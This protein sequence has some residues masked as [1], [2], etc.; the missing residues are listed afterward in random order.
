MNELPEGVQ[1][2]FAHVSLPNMAER[3]NGGGGGIT[4][5]K[6][7]VAFLHICVLVEGPSVLGKEGE[8]G[9]ARGGGG[10]VNVTWQQ[11][12][13]HGWLPRVMQHRVGGPVT[14]RTFFTR[15]TSWGCRKIANT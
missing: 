9:T 6:V 2:N 4:Y 10:K 8:R 5:L 15:Q 11:N 3:C 14:K 13:T 12:S 7:N 1:Y